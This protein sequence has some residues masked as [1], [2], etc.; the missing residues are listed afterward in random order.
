[1]LF[2]RLFARCATHGHAVFLPSQV[3][4]QDIFHVPQGTRVI[5]QLVLRER[6]LHQIAILRG[7]A[8]DVPKRQ[9]QAKEH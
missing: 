9:G 5:Q 4:H 1:M 8:Y 3:K 7:L 2:P 6:A